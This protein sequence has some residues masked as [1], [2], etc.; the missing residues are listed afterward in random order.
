VL[1]DYT[2]LPLITSRLLLGLKQV[3]RPKTLQRMMMMV[4]KST[5][6]GFSTNDQDIDNKIVSFFCDYVK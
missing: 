1:I 4:V 2:F 5:L 3:K 6:Q